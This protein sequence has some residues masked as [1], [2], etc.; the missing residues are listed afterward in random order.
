MV[1]YDAIKQLQKYAKKVKSATDESLKK[2]TIGG[3]EIAQ[4]TA[5]FMNAYD[6]GE[7]VDGIQPE[8]RSGKGIIHSTAGH[9]AYVEMG[10]GVVGS[11]NPNPNGT[12]PGW[13]YDVNQH[14]EA[15]WHYVGRDGH[16]HWTK[17][18]PSRPFMYDTAQILKA[19]I[20]ET[21][22]EELKRD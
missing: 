12:M 7:L 19:A 15:G 9:S 13:K 11:N 14:G 10:T 1:P 18:M 17:G 21:V 16:L 8:I 4:R 22:K 3:A 2:V 20:P 6:S 5:M